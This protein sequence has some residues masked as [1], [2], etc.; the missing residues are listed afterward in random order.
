MTQEEY[1]KSADRKRKK[2]ESELLILLLILIGNAIRESMLSFRH[3]LNWRQVLDNRILGYPEARM[4]GAIPAIIGTLRKSH[5]SGARLAAER[6]GEVF[7]G[8]TRNDIYETA[9][10]DFSVAMNNAVQS[11]FWRGIGAGTD[12]RNTIKAIRIEI[13]TAGYSIGNYF[14]IE[15]GVG[16]AVVWSFNLGV[17][18]VSNNFREVTQELGLRHVSVIDDRTSD[19]CIPRDG[20]TLP[21]S[22]P[23]WRARNVPPLHPRCRSLLMPMILPYEETDVP[24]APAAALGF[25]ENPLPLGVS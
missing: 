8:E 5:N 1:I 23:Y 21:V 18:D 24:I 16:R 11:A 15:L 12:I 10:R 25:G 17:I 6:L 2:R 13:D 19:W 7:R 9:A 20:T 14:A 4:K 22:H 3:G